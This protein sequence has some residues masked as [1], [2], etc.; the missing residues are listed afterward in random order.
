MLDNL[1]KIRCLTEALIFG[2]IKSI[3]NETN[4]MSRANTRDKQS[5]IKYEKWM[6]ED[7]L[8]DN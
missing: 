5:V 6:K 3:K 8:H 7:N 1:D 4:S 2:T